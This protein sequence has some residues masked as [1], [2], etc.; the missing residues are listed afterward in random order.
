MLNNLPFLDLH[1]E[2]REVTRILV[3]EFISDNIKM[4]NY[5]ICI[6]HGIG[7]GILRREVRSILLKDARV[8]KF[9]IDFFNVGSTIVELKEKY[10]Q[11][12]CYVVSYRA[13][14]Q[15]GNI[16]VYWRKAKERL[17]N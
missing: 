14:K 4:G 5:K 8:E 17:T 16:Y 15:R 11:E 3:N 13:H 7:D 6:I 1:G 9:Y 12:I 10:W 2:N